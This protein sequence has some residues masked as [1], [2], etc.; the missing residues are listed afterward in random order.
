LG[1]DPIPYYRGRVSLA[2]ELWRK[3]EPEFEKPGNRYQKFR[4]VFN[5][6]ISQYFIAV[7]NV[8][9]YIGGIYYH[10]DHV[11]D[12]NGR[13]PFVPVSAD[14]QREALEFLKTNVFGPEA[15]K[16][17][18]D[19]LNKLA[20]ERFWNFSGSIWRMTRIDYPI[21]NVVHSIQNYAL[22]HLYHS[23]LLSRLVDLELRYK[24]G[25][26]PF[27]LPDMFQGVREAVWSELSGSTNINSFRR[28]LQRSHLD[29]LVTL[30][31]KPNKSVPE[32]ASTLARADLVNLKEG[33]D[34]ALSSGGLNAYTRAHLDET[35]ARIDAALKAGIERQI[36]L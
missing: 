14:K 15:F 19:L 34:Q 35:R 7:S 33:I 16:F 4:D 22:N 21:H 29:K 10:R 31:V 17:S 2:Q 9:K 6:G 32:D 18:P 24:E 28:A 26:K 25:E 23:I 1:A 5:Q 13:I 8:A 27:T 3:I 20:P 30:V 11:D 36:G 12:P